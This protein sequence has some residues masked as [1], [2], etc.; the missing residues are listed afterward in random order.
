MTLPYYDELLLLIYKSTSQQL[1]FLFSLLKARHC[2]KLTNYMCCLINSQ[3]HTLSRHYYYSHCTDDA[4]GSKREITGKCLVMR[5]GRSCAGIQAVWVQSPSSFLPENVSSL[6]LG[7]GFFWLWMP[8]NSLETKIQCL[9]PFPPS[10]C[11]SVGK[12][13]VLAVF[14]V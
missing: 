6:E 10:P 12:Q 1:P 9:L 5:K 14:L 8:E 13:W 7:W 2:S 3:N 4:T 11:R